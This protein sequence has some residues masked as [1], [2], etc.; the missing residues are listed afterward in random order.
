MLPYG[1]RSWQIDLRCSTSIG[2]RW[3]V[4]PRSSSCSRAE[5]TLLTD[6]YTT[7]LPPSGFFF[8]SATWTLNSMSRIS[9]NTK[10]P[11]ACSS[12]CTCSAL[13][14]A[15]HHAAT[16]RVSSAKSM[17]DVMR[18]PAS[19]DTARTSHAVASDANRQGTF[20]HAG[21]CSRYVPSCCLPCRRGTSDE[22]QKGPP[23]TFRSGAASASWACRAWTRALASPDCVGPHF[24]VRSTHQADRR[25]RC[26][27]AALYLDD[28]LWVPVAQAPRRSFRGSGVHLL[29]IM[30][31]ADYVGRHSRILAEAADSSS[32]VT[33]ARVGLCR[34]V[35]QVYSPGCVGFCGGWPA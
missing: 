34:G 29:E 18:E 5:P 19:A 2:P 12:T 6:Q 13:N 23:F 24:Q 28:R 16:A 33:S 22:N 25:G 17:T 26:F 3:G 8:G 31:Q 7:G 4:A 27:P 1:S 35:Y 9:K 20:V 10:G 21:A 15:A 32:G 30:A 14:A 11:C